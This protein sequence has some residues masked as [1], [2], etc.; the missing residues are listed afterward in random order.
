MRFHVNSGA[1]NA[2]IMTTTAHRTAKLAARMSL[3]AAT[4]AAIADLAFGA[5]HRD[6]TVLL[7]NLVAERVSSVG[8]AR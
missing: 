8:G 2:P 7:A 5:G 3:P 4:S 1:R 6:H